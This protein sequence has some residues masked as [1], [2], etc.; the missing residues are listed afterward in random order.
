MKNLFNRLIVTLSLVIGSNLAH[1]D[2]IANPT[3]SSSNLSYAT[4]P[5]AQLQ[6]AA[7]SGQAVAQF[8]LGNHYKVGQGVRRDLD[9]AFAWFKKAAD[10]GIPSAQLNV[11]QMYASGLGVRKDLNAAKNYFM[12]AA[13]MGDNRASYNLAVLEERAKNYAAAY[14]WYELSTRD[15]MLDF[16]VK[17]MSEQKIVQLAA[18]LSPNDMRM[19]RERSDRWIQ[20]DY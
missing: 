14:Q 13:R 3:S 8:F 12:K 7:Q 16:R 19:A 9:Q 18:N 5:I 2:L 10:Q 17:N 6:Q 1:A 15:G 20:S 11:G 4:M